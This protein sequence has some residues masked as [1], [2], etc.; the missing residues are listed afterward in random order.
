LSYSL[1]G[2]LFII[3]EENI[4]PVNVP[5]AEF[6][7]FIISGGVTEIDENAEHD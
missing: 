3:P 4:K 6:M 5:A 7:K 1:S 2:D